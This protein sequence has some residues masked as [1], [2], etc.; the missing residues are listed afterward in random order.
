M[1][2]PMQNGGPPSA[3][4]A[5]SVCTQPEHRAAIVIYCA[6]HGVKAIYAEK[7]F[8]AGVDEAGTVILTENDSND[9]KIS[10]KIPKEW[11]LMAINNGV[12]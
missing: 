7:A 10:K 5:V 4:W 11:Q 12:E 1:T 3:R 9:S 8:A 2:R 6:E